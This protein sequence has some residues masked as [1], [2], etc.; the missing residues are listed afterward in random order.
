MKEEKRFIETLK[1]GV[2]LGYIQEF[3]KAGI[4]SIVDSNVESVKDI[5][6][7]YKFEVTDTGL[8]RIEDLILSLT[9]QA[10]TMP[11][12]SDLLAKSG[13]SKEDAALMMMLS[14]HKQFPDIFQA[15][16]FLEYH[17]NDWS[18]VLG[19]AKVG[20]LNSTTGEVVKKV[21]INESLDALLP[22]DGNDDIVTMST[23]E[24]KKPTFH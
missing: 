11:M 2:R 10:V 3:V 1:E 14:I 6:G 9:D 18:A 17:K 7:V 4:P 8:K 12:V 20:I 15:Y 5:P 16:L 21:D 13:A 22:T 19:N 24:N 23:P